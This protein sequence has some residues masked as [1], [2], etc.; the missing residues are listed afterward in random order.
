MKY[1]ENYQ[2][3][4]QWY[5]VNKCFWKYGTNRLAP[6]RVSANVHSIKNSASVKHNVAKYNKIRYD[7]TLV[8][9][10]AKEPLDEN[11]RGEWKNWL[12]TQHPEN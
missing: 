3:M 2:D 6:H 8:S 9:S 11:E 12:K 1:C 10:R 5:E 4:A 7:C